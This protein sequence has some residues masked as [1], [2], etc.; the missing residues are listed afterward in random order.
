MP[1]GNPSHRDADLSKVSEI[2][3]VVSLSHSNKAKI[4]M[5]AFDKLMITLKRLTTL[6]GGGHDMGILENKGERKWIVTKQ[7]LAEIHL[8]GSVP[9]R[10]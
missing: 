4:S 5:K 7:S 2:L 3:R 8:S 1:N 9:K 10:K 6:A